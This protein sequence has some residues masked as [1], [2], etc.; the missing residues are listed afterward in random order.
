MEREDSSRAASHVLRSIFGVAVAMMN[1]PTLRS[2]MSSFWKL[3]L[4]SSLLGCTV[5]VAQ[6]SG[7]FSHLRIQSSAVWAD[8][9]SRTSHLPTQKSSQIYNLIGTVDHRHQ[10]DRNWMLITEVELAGQ[11]VTQYDALNNINATT[12]LKLRHKFGLGPFATV[13]DFSTQLTGT[14][15]KETGRNGWLFEAGASASKRITESLQLTGGASWNHFSAKR[16]T[17]NVSTD[18]LFLEGSWD[19]T[20]RWRISLGGSRIEGKFVAN[21]AGAIWSSAIGGQLGPEISQHYNTL[22]WE[23]SDTFG[24]GWV[25]Y[26]NR[27]SNVDQ[28]WVELSP[29]LSDQ[30]SLSLRYEFNKAINAIGIRYDTIFWSLGLNHQF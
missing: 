24:P 29:A 5:G 22:A 8:N 10:L 26:R 18:R 11:Y 15:F 12:R 6:P 25:A 30:T 2:N 9:L 16:N 27:E 20:D 28:W 13:I 14:S 3:A 1:N 19:I 4:M 21:A 23:V 17:Y 7:I